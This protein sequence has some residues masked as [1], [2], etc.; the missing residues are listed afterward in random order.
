M[1]ADSIEGTLRSFHGN[2]GETSLYMTHSPEL[3]HLELAVDEPTD[4]ERPAFSYHSRKI[5][6]SG[7]IGRPS[8]ASAEKGRRIL[9]YAI[10]DVAALIE[11]AMREPMPPDIWDVKQA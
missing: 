8:A 7:C 1:Y 9:A 4:P 5:T 10:E 2:D 3:V 6:A 11:R